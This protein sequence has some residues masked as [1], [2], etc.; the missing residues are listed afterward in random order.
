MRTADGKSVE[1][2]LAA[3]AELTAPLNDLRWLIARDVA[4]EWAAT[5][6]CDKIMERRGP[7]LAGRVMIA[8]AWYVCTGSVSSGRHGW[9]ELSM[10]EAIPLEAWPY[11]GTFAYGQRFNERLCRRLG[12]NYFG[13]GPLRM[14]GRN[15]GDHVLGWDWTALVV[16][17]LE[18]GRVVPVYGE[19]I[20]P[21]RPF[22]YELED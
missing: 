1:R 11:H 7:H 14:K 15:A 18:P 2:T 17:D 21:R 16:R 9:H 3:W 22:P 4:E 13:V 5:Y 10:S 8:G 12:R 6:S 20:L 19:L